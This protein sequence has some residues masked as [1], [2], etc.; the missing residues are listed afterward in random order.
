MLISKTILSK[1]KFYY[2]VKIVHFKKETITKNTHLLLN[3]IELN[4]NITTFYFGCNKKKN[5]TSH[6][7]Y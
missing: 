5:V 4:R 7:K 1:N 6:N 2:I 3:I